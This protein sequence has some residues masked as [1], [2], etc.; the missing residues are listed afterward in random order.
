MP[1]SEIIILQDSY[2]MEH[3]AI[4]SVSKWL[5]RFKSRTQKVLLG[6]TNLRNDLSGSV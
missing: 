6:P 1:Q 2:E 4:L 5:Q 3:A